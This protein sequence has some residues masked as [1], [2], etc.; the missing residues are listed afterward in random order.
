MFH[1]PVFGDEINDVRDAT[2]RKA[3]HMNYTILNTQYKIIIEAIMLSIQPI[4]RTQRSTSWRH[5][6]G[7]RLRAREPWAAQVAAP[8][9][10]WDGPVRSFA[11]GFSAAILRSGTPSTWKDLQRAPFL[12]AAGPRGHSATCTL[13]STSLLFLPV[14]PPS[15]V[16]PARI[17][18]MST[19][20]VNYWCSA[21]HCSETQLRNA[22]LAVGLL[23]ADVKAYLSR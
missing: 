2:R 6:W 5:A 7:S 23:P 11:L 18:L 8:R 15:S 22:I 3:V 9:T 19:I 21:L 17:N 4:E 16:D 20:A 13:P 14:N 12:L 1:I 10:R